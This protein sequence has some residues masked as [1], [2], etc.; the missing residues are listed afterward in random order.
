M[1]FKKIVTIGSIVILGLVGMFSD[2]IPDNVENGIKQV[3]SIVNTVSGAID[4]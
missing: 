3:V 4:E 1:K 2:K